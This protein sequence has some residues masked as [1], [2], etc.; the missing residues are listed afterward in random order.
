MR[1]DSNIGKGERWRKERVAIALDKMLQED[2]V[3]YEQIL[4][5]RASFP[6]NVL[7]L[8]AQNP[9]WSYEDTCEYL[10]TGSKKRKDWYKADAGA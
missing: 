3:L 4:E 6:F 2:K 7:C 10:R 5:S 8:M 1:G 9:Y